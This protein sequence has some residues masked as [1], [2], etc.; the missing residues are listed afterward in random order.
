VVLSFGTL[1]GGVFGLMFMSSPLP[2]DPGFGAGLSA[3]KLSFSS[4]ACP[5]AIAGGD[6]LMS[7]PGDLYADDFFGGFGCAA[8]RT[9]ADLFCLLALAMALLICDRSALLL[10]RFAMLQFWGIMILFLAA[11]GKAA[12]GLP[13]QSKRREFAGCC[14][15][16]RQLLSFL[17]EAGCAIGRLCVC[18]CA[19]KRPGGIEALRCECECRSPGRERGRP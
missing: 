12:C 2:L 9:L 10:A 15:K 19:S 1:R 8:T 5:S 6:A 18:E 3:G 11:A 7:G 4:W 14:R 17:P 16:A 13:H